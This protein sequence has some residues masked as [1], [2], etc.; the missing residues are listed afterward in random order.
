MKGQ[1]SLMQGQPFSARRPVA[2]R[3]IGLLGLAAVGALLSIGPAAALPLGFPTSEAGWSGAQLALGMGSASVVALLGGLYFFGF[4]GL[5]HVNKENVLEHPMRRSLLEMVSA[6]PGIHL[7]ELASRHGT[8]VT[9]TQW[10][11]R[12]LEQAHLV[13]TQ[14][15]QGRRLYYPVQGGV[16]SRERAV[17]NA[18]KRNPNAAQLVQYLE[19]HPGSSQRALAAGLDM[20]PGTVRWHLRRLE[21]SGLLRTIQEGSQTRYFLM[22]RSKPGDTAGSTPEPVGVDSR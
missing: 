22:S 17:Q 11:L 20:N 5:R 10:H 16:D 14:K 13:R 1:T 2:A 15:V 12:K 4:G 7:R 3:R 8:A 19:L 21:Q 18:A 9:N 6:E